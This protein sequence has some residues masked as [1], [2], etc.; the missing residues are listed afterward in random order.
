MTMVRP[1]PTGRAKPRFY[2]AQ[3]RK[4]N[5]RSRL[6]PLPGTPRPLASPR[7]ESRA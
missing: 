1:M 6:T 7:Q 2:P 3:A 4:S 5:M